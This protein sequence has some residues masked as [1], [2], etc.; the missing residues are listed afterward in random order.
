MKQLN[1]FVIEKLIIN[2]NTNI[3]N[4]YKIYG[5]GELS[6]LNVKDFVYN[7]FNINMSQYQINEFNK[8]LKTYNIDPNTEFYH[9]KDKDI[10]LNGKL[11][12]LI[13]TEK[14]KQCS[15]I[16]IEQLQI[17]FYKLQN[18]FIIIFVIYDQHIGHLINEYFLYNYE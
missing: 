4:S 15:I 9:I 16:Y 11:V 18:I 6:V 17:F 12:N 13:K 14:N 5:E 8:Q 10:P 3:Q 2:K 7:T 1:N